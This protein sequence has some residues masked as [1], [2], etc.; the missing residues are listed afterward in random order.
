MGCIKFMFSTKTLQN[1]VTLRKPPFIWL[2]ILRVCHLG[3]G[4]QGGSADLGQLG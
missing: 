3:W 1:L 4:Q 2:M